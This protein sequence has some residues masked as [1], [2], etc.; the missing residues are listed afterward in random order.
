VGFKELQ[1]KVKQLSTT[2]S[3]SM[4]LQKEQFHEMKMKYFKSL[5]GQ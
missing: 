3:I 4:A 5:L 1:T 2:L